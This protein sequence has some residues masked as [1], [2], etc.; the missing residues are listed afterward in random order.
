ME[1]LGMVIGID[2]NKIDEY[3]HL[4]KNAWDEILQSLSDAH[5]TNYS[6][7]LNE[8]EN[9]LFSYFEYIGTDF[10]KDMDKMADLDIT[11]RW[12]ELCMPCQKPLDTRKQGEWWSQMDEVFYHA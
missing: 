8:P 7:F 6:I 3:K 11:K 12:W 5:I 1:R 10:K 9:L 4:H 2:P